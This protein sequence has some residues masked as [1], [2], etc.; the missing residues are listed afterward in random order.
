MCLLKQ[1]YQSRTF[2]II[3]QMLY[4]IDTKEKYIEKLERWNF[5]FRTLFRIWFHYYT[6]GFCK[7]DFMINQKI[8]FIVQRKKISIHESTIV[9]CLIALDI[10]GLD[11]IF[12][13]AHCFWSMSKTAFHSLYCLKK[14]KNRKVPSRS[15]RVDLFTAINLRFIT[16]DT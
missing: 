10:W 12:R 7:A 2:G 9:N 6:V 14:K 5:L 3:F 13:F 15:C 1:G 11:L 8:L 16:R 4:I